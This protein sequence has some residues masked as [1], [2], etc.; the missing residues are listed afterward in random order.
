M[1]T[2][3]TTTSTTTTTT[4]GLPTLSTCPFVVQAVVEDGRGRLDVIQYDEEFADPN[5]AA[6]F[7]RA[8]MDRNPFTVEAKVALWFRSAV[9]DVEDGFV[10]FRHLTK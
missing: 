9:P 10:M 1:T 2:T 3:T 7:G 5:T 8:E 4:A 6:A